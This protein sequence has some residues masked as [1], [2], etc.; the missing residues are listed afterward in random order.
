LRKWAILL[1]ALAGLAFIAWEAFVLSADVRI[2]CVETL[3]L[4]GPRAFPLVHEF[5]HDRDRRVAIAA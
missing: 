5:Q 1:L 2:V 3:G 4:L